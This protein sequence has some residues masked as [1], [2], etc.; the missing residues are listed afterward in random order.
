MSRNLKELVVQ[1]QSLDHF[2]TWAAIEDPF[3]LLLG[4]NPTPMDVSVTESKTGDQGEL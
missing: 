3:A 1:G 2:D 4:N